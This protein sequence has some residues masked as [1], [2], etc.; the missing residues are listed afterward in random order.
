V[1]AKDNALTGVEKDLDLVPFLLDDEPS[2]RSLNSLTVC[3]E[4]IDRRLGVEDSLAEEI[5]CCITFEPVQVFS[6]DAKG[7]LQTVICGV[8]PDNPSRISRGSS[9]ISTS[10]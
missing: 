3:I 6:R 9:P 2:I 7:D 5:V 1:F 8:S 10:V 4:L